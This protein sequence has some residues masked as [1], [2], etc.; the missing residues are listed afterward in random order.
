MGIIDFLFKSEKQRQV[1][2]L[3]VIADKIEAL[4]PKYVAMSDEELKSQTDLFRNR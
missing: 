2:K 3:G 4:E 1:K